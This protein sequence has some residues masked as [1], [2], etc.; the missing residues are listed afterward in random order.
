M[1]RAKTVK[2]EGVAKAAAL[3]PPPVEL[4]PV[5]PPVE[6]KDEGATV[7]R[8]ALRKAEG[9]APLGQLVTIFKL[10]IAETT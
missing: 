4:N 3:L 10:N 9:E 6:L 5:E 8:L 2:I 1:Q 7:G